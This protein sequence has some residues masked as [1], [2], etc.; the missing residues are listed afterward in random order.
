M[1]TNIQIEEIIKRGLVNIDPFDSAQLEVNHYKL[2]VDSIILRKTDDVYAL[3][4]N[5]Y[6]LSEGPYALEP[7]EYV[8]VVIKEK[9]VLGKGMFGEFYPASLNIEKGLILNCG[10][11]NS[12]YERPIHFGLLNA[13]PIEYRLNKGDEIA[14]II[15]RYIGDDVPIDYDRKTSDPKYLAMIQE[16]RKTEKE[17]MDLENELNKKK[18][19]VKKIKGEM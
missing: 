19:A 4:M 5:P 10:R 9:I 1:L 17:I 11:L 3:N 2:R 14:R 7:N 12:F 6:D 18:E 13:S 15:F 8:I 16:L